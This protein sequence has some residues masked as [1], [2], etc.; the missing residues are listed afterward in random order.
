MHFRTRT[1]LEQMLL[2]VVHKAS[3]FMIPFLRNDRQRETGTAV[4]RNMGHIFK[5]QDHS[6]ALMAQLRIHRYH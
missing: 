2:D 6:E 3:Y 5:S 1:N 4:S